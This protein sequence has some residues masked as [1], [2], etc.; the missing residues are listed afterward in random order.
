[1][2]IGE[3]ITLETL[4]VDDEPLARELMASYVRQTPFLHLAGVFGS[5]VEALDALRAQRIDL[6][7]LDIQMPQ[8]SGMELSRMLDNRVRVIFTTAFEKYALE[9]FR[10]DALDYLL[11]PISYAEFLR[12]ADKAQRWFARGDAEV[13]LQTQPVAQPLPSQP[14]QSLFVKAD[15]KM[16]QLELSDIEYVEGEKDYLKIHMA[17]GRRVMTLMSLKTMEESLPAE[18]FVRV[19]RS[20]IVN[21]ERIRTIERNRIV[22]GKVYIPISDTYKEAFMQL[23]SRRSI[24]I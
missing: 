3:M 13:S 16:V 10:V 22:F 20:F 8:L 24:V 15:Y 7:L 23:L 6:L 4:V 5:A 9:G 17:D 2:A 21:V 19:H 12:A 14:A 11:K 18:R 1:M